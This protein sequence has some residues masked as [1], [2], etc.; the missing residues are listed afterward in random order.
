MTEQPTEP[1]VPEPFFWTCPDFATNQ[2]K[3]FD[4]IR[5]DYN[6]L[7]GPERELYV[8]FERE[9]REFSII[10]LKSYEYHSIADSLSL[11]TQELRTSFV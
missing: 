6:E 2:D 8:V 9:A 7:T 10:S 3:P 11:L 5:K 4:R 1:E